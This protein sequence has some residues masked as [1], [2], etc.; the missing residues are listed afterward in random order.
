M[1]FIYLF[2]SN[3]INNYLDQRLIIP[4]DHV[5]LGSGSPS[6]IHS[7]SKPTLRSGTSA[8]PSGS[9]LTILAAPSGGRISRIDKDNVEIL[10]QFLAFYNLRVKLNN[11]NKWVLNYTWTSS[12]LRII[13]AVLL[14]RLANSTRLAFGSIR[15]AASRSYDLT[16]IFNNWCIS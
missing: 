6:A 2:M 9:I 11:S 14:N 1:I 10:E 12:D 16:K 8:K 15:S 7:S 13:L 4:L 5:T 3:N